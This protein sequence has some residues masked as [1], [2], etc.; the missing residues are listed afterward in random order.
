MLFSTSLAGEVASL[1]KAGSFAGKNLV[2]QL[3]AVAEGL[4]AQKVADVLL[5]QTAVPAPRGHDDIQERS[6][7]LLVVSGALDL[8]R[9]ASKVVKERV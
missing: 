5:V 8:L 6:Q 1:F 4:R 9:G 7:T 3:A 2:G